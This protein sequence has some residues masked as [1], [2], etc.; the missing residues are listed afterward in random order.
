[1][2]VDEGAAHDLDHDSD[3]HPAIRSRWSTSANETLSDD[4]NP[5]AR[6]T[7]GFRCTQSDREAGKQSKIKNRL[8]A[9]RS[10]RIHQIRGWLAREEGGGR[11]GDDGITHSWPKNSSM[12]S[13]QEPT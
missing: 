12:A 4:R 1:V 5:G 3:S 11:G 6:I 9:T 7:L 10:R 13:S 8:E 2:G